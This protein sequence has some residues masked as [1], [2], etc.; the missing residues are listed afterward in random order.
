MTYLGPPEGRGYFAVGYSKW[1]SGQTCWIHEG[2]PLAT[3][4]AAAGMFIVEGE[5]V[6]DARKVELFYVDDEGK[7]QPAPIILSWNWKD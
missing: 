4:I 2:G 7:V 1:H 5:E 6:D 3:V